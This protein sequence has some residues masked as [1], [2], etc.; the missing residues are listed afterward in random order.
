MNRHWTSFGWILL[1][2]LG[3]VASLTAEERKPN[4][5]FIYTDDHRWD[6]VGMVQQEQGDRARF[7]WF[8]SP[9]LDR[10]ANEGVR[11]R[12]AFVVL[13]LCSPSR[14]AFLTGRYNHANG[15]VTNGRPFP[16]DSVTHASLMRA[17]GYRTAYIGKWHMGD[18]RGQRP[19]FDYSASYVGQGNYQ[20]C[21]FEING[22]ATPTQGWVDDVSTDYALDWIKQNRDEPFSL[23]LGFKSP[24]S[25]RGGQHLPE[26]LRQLYDGEI[27]RATPNCGVPAIFHQRDPQTGKHASGLAD[28]AIHLD[29]LRHI[30]GVDENVGRML[31][32]LDELGLAED[33]VVVYSSDN[34][35]FLGEHCSGDKR[36][37]YEESLRV[38]ML[39]RYPRQFAR[40]L[41]VDELVLNVDLAPTFLDLAGVP[42]PREMQGASWKELAAGHQPENWRHS[43]LAEYYKELGGV[44]TCY[45]VRTKTHKLVRYPN[46]P[47]W[48]EVFDLQA[49]PYEIRNLAADAE[50]TAKLQVELDSVVAAT[51][52][53]IPENANRPKPNSQPSPAP[54]PVK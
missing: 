8:Q 6:A 53:K 12:N 11:F 10:L 28:N 22:K 17:A 23:V 47:E 9:S 43:F 35:F 24:H 13:S 27:S 25:P 37:L 33:T 29:Y 32:A 19:G 36:A 7:P 54:Q 34:G 14:A 4:F 39:V 21:S 5:V 2:T 50:L 20:N 46:R 18:Q 30:K 52:Y 41:V 15:M 44:P 49:D 16:A 45:A 1:I 3:G 51:E 48:T 40:G 26:R 38:P 31:D 42:V